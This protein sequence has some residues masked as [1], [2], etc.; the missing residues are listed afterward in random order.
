MRLSLFFWVTIAFV[1]VGVMMLLLQP[2]IDPGSLVALI[3]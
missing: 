2:L 3:N 1:V